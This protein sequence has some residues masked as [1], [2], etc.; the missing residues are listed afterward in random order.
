MNLT[1]QNAKNLISKDDKLSKTAAQIIL[2]KCDI[3][4]FQTLCENAGYMFDFILEKVIKNL[5]IATNENNLNSTFK[6]AKFYNPQTEEY[7]LKSW[8]KFANEDLTDEILELLETGTDEQKIYAAKYFE[9]IN[10]PLCLDCLKKY[11]LSDNE[12]L[13]A[14]CAKTLG[15]FNE[16]ESRNK[17]LELLNNNDDFKKFSAINFLINYDKTD[18]LKI[19]INEIENSPLGASIAQSLLYKY[20]FTKLS[21]YLSKEDILKVLDEIISAYPEDIGLETVLDFNLIEAIEKFAK[22]QN[23][24]A[25][26]IIADAKNVFNLVCSENIYTYDLNR[27]YLKAVK[28]LDCALKNYNLDTDLIANELFETQK[29]AQRAI[30]TIINLNSKNAENKIVEL[31]KTTQ[32]PLLLC[33]CARAAKSLGF[34]I[35]V[36]TGINKIKDSNAQELFKSYF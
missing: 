7:I 23:S 6:F 25:Q 28:E 5:L 12:D 29:R 16:Q 34:N 35:D 14:A 22:E 15:V 20:D 3:A 8:L 36:E 1:T 31:Y 11:A 26:R 21:N 10:D 30:N 9:K 13:A 4:S 32:D 33:E 24:F 17:A 18:D 2:D 27:D 19:I